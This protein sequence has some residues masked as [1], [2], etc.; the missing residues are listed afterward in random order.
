MSHNDQPPESNIEGWIRSKYEYKKWVM[1]SSIPDPKTLLDNNDQPSTPS[2]LLDSQSAPSTSPKASS[3]D[4]PFSGLDIFLSLPQSSATSGR[5]TPAA[6]LGAEL[7]ALDFEKSTTHSAPVTPAS[8]RPHTP[9]A[10]VQHSSSN[11]HAQ[12]KSSILSLYN[13]SPVSQSQT[14]SFTHTTTRVDSAY[15]K[16]FSP[17]DTK[18]DSGYLN[19]LSNMFTTIPSASRGGSDKTNNPIQACPAAGSFSQTIELLNISGGSQATP[20]SSSSNLSRNTPPRPMP[21][22]TSDTQDIFLDNPWAEPKSSEA[23]ITK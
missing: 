15:S 16:F 10:C 21:S 6:P 11:K 8:S 20:L 17:Q 7:F 12:L 18:Q 2:Y 1:S 3:S 23:K 22:S 13:S 4:K 14:S 5:S 19:E 9:Q